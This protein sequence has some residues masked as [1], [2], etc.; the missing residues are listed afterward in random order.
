MKPTLFKERLDSLM[1]DA[2]N[3]S[4]GPPIGYMIMALEV[5]KAKAVSVQLQ[6]EAVQK[7]QE[8]ASKIL[9]A[10]GKIPPLQPPR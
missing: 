9:P 7:Q 5:A 8:M 6:F 3:S 1:E 2:F 4:E 10:N